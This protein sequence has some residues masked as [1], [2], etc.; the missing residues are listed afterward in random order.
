MLACHSNLWGCIFSYQHYHIA[1]DVMLE[2]FVLQMFQHTSLLTPL[3]VAVTQRDLDMCE[4]L[5]GKGA[6]VNATD[7]HQMTP[8]MH[9]VKV[10]SFKGCL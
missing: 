9:A 7:G 10:V 4:F 2:N 1:S 6:D 8:L 5:L 3:C